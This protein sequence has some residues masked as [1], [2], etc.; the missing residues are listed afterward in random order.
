MQGQP[1]GPSANQDGRVQEHDY[2]Q[3]S[4][5]GSLSYLNAGNDDHLVR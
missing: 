1:Q 3:R 5:M 2:A 4:E